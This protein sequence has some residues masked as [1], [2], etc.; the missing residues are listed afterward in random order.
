MDVKDFCGGMETELKEWKAKF[1]DAI[2]KSDELGTADKEK[3]MAYF[4]N[5]KI[6]VTEMEAKIDQLKTECPADWSPQ[7]KEIDDGV[8]DL[9]SQYEETM[10]FIGKAAPVSV[11]G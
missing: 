11:P 4:N 9:R 1:F 2:A 8:V 6:L 3:A 10:N 5:V 7:K